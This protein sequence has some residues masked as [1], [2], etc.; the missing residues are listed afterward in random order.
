ME[1][2]D[3]TAVGELLIDFTPAGTTAAGAACYARNAGGA[4]ANVL[5]MAAHLGVRTAFIGKVGA[6]GFGD[7]LAQTLLDNGVEVSGLV[8][9][10]SAF[11]TLA[12]VSL[13]KGGERTFDFCRKPGADT[14]LRPEELNAQ[15]LSHTRWLHFGSVSLSQQPAAGA[16]LAAV[17]A[18]KAA[19]AC[20][21]FDPNY[22]PFLWDSPKAAVQAIR[23]AA[24][25]ADVIKLSQEELELLFDGAADDPEQGA[26]A[27]L[28]QGAA[29]VLVTLGSQGARAYTKNA[30]ACAAGFQV[31]AV[32][33]TG[34]G[35]AFTGAALAALKDFT[36]RQ[37]ESMSADA[38]AQ[39]LRRANACGA[40]T[41]TAY[42][43][44][45]ALPTAQELA[46]FLQ[47]NG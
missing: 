31:D 27:L 47:K 37:I 13:G 36:R 11:T 46:R 28:A 42:G 38:L 23:L 7:F 5:A 43:A 4:P 44:I 10:A 14:L 16:T 18:A 6:D 26:R 20:I 22:R 39:L 30:D 9:D 17:R 2:M 24:G 12:F 40:L 1:M 21:S 8:R 19:G 32:D 41:V 45:P 35:D 25:M 15:L 29:L 33:T 34:A 3:L